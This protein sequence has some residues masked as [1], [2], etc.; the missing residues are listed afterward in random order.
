MR[1]AGHQPVL[2]AALL[3]APALLGCP[4]TTSAVLRIDPPPPGRGEPADTQQKR[5]EAAVREVAAARQLACAPGRDELL[6][7]W[8]GTLGSSSAFTSLHLR[9]AGTGYEVDVVGSS[10]AGGQ[11][12]RIQKTLAERIDAAV[13][14]PSA[15]VDP[16]RCPAAAGKR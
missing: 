4:G 15:H 3:L 14:A 8:P 5:I 11:L 6:G 13:G 2:L 10:G 1:P 16:R 7:C 9:A 12:C